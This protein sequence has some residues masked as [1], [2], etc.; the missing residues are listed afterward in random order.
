MRAAPDRRRLEGQSLQ[1]LSRSNLQSDVERRESGFMSVFYL[2]ATSALS[3]H[4]LASS[5]ILT[6][7]TRHTQPEMERVAQGSK[8]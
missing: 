5:T 1:P 8:L 4:D 7:D 3:S 6:R 2:V